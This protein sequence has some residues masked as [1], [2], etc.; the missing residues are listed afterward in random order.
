MTFALSRRGLFGLMAGAAVVAGGARVL[1]AEP[2]TVAFHDYGVAPDITGI[3]HWLNSAPLTL[4]GLRGQVVLVD[5]W[6]Y[7]CINCVRTLPYVTGW[8]RTFASRGLVIIGV[9]TPEFGYEKSTRNVEAA[10][11][12]HGIAYPVAQ[13]NQ[14]ATWKAFDNEYWPATYLIDRRGH[15]VMK[16]AGEGAYDATERAI[17]TLIDAKMEAGQ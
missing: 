16:H 2:E 5:F 13:D 1:R 11:S 17:A 8:H 4:A 12:R 15:I 10:I 3:E 14:Y 6:T 7:S 9:H